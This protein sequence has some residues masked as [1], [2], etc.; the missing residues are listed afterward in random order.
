MLTDVLTRQGIEADAITFLVEWLEQ[1][2]EGESDRP[3]WAIRA[4]GE[5]AL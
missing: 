4:E 2:G 3:C 1:P 5:A